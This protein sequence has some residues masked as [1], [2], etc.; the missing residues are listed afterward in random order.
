VKLGA[1]VLCRFA[2]ITALEVVTGNME[3]RSLP[4]IS[5]GQVHRGLVE[6]VHLPKG[7]NNSAWS[8]IKFWEGS[9]V[10]FREGSVIKLSVGECRT[11]SPIFPRLRTRGSMWSWWSEF[12]M[13]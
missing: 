3:V 4:T 5:V 6:K 1:K 11:K 2:K 12:R 7:A 10:K 13:W 8:V 9:V